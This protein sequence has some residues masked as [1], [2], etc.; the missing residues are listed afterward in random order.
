MRPPAVAREQV[1][2]FGT[3]PRSVVVPRLLEGVNH[4]LTEL[5]Q[6]VERTTAA[7]DLARADLARTE[8]HHDAVLLRAESVQQ[9]LLA[10]RTR[11]HH[12]RHRARQA[13]ALLLCLGSVGGFAARWGGATWRQAQLE[14][15]PV[16]VA[17]TSRR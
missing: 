12:L 3:S 16:L 2:G 17:E 5:G 15:S 6:L 8:E 11:L 14:S 1:V 9:D 4:Q 10:F 7:V 13:S